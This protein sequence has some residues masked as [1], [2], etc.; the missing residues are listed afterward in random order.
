MTVLAKK[1]HELSFS[2]LSNVDFHKDPWCELVQS[3][4]GWMSGF[5]LGEVEVKGRKGGTQACTDWTCRREF[6]FV[7]YPAN[8]ALGLGS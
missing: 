2:C 8:W 3:M 1:Y 4:G 7:S 5:W 6:P